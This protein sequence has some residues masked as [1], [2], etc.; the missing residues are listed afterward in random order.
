[1]SDYFD[2]LIREGRDTDAMRLLAR[3]YYE[4]GKMGYTRMSLLVRL[5]NENDKLKIDNEFLVKKQSVAIEDINNLCTDH[6]RYADD[7]DLLA[8]TCGNFCIYGKIGKCF[9]AD[10]VE[11]N[12]CIKFQWRG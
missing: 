9:E 8:D 2:D 6:Y 12:K 1:M 11:P 7:Y 10:E 3:E 5:A 4:N